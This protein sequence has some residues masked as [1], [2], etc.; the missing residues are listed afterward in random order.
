VLQSA[1]RT[2]DSLAPGESQSV[3]LPIAGEGKQVVIALV[4]AGAQRA[5]EIPIP[6]QR[7]SVVPP[8]TSLARAGGLR[9]PSVRL[10]AAADPGLRQGWLKVDGAKRA[11]E[12]WDGR[13]AAA[14]AAPLEH[15]G[16]AQV[17]SKVEGQDGV[18][19]LDSR[20]FIA[21]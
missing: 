18:A 6:E 20:L 8:R 13:A 15:D 3:V 10:D 16:Y 5:F 2:I 14:L 7:A 9:G 17:Q 4:G 1:L 11:F 19:V 12:R 21:E